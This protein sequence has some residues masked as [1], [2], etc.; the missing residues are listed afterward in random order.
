MRFSTSTKTLASAILIILSLATTTLAAPSTPEP[1]T[2]EICISRT[3][4][5][6]VP[7]CS[8]SGSKAPP[9]LPN[10][11]YDYPKLNQEQKA[12]LCQLSLNDN[13]IKLCSGPMDC[14]AEMAKAMSEALPKINNN[15][16]P[17]DTKSAA[18][19]G[20]KVAG[21]LTA[22]AVVAVSTFLL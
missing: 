9:L 10:G 15:T 14:G 19:P 22:V 17:A 21:G 12:C 20:R 3:G 5:A 6:Q 4:L 8:A 13:W 18:I 7:A 11:E 2:C 16:C 1:N